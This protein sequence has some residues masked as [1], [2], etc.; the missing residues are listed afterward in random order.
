MA[1]M[2]LRIVRESAA[3]DDSLEASKSRRQKRM[4]KEAIQVQ[5]QRPFL[6]GLKPFSH[7]NIIMI[8][9]LPG[10]ARDKRTV[11]KEKLPLT[12]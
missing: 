1:K 12:N 10:Q 7:H 6:C 9:H 2:V 5:K 4:E 8:D 11:S 3:V